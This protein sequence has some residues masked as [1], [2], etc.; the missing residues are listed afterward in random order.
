MTNTDLGL[1]GRER[2][3]EALDAYSRGLSDAPLLHKWTK[4]D[5]TAADR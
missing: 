5:V 2:L 1:W 3:L 4:S